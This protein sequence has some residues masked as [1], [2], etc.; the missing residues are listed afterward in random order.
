M[1]RD[2]TFERLARIESR[3]FCPSC[4]AIHR[5]DRQSAVLEG[6]I[7]GDLEGTTNRPL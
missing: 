7:P 5:W 4:A 3:V 1:V 2:D 6:D